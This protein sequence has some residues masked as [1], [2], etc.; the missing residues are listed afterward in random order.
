M[1]ILDSFFC[2]FELF[3]RTIFVI[4]WLISVYL[5][6]FFDSFYS[7]S[8]NFCSFSTRFNSIL[9]NFLQFPTLNKSFTAGRRNL[10]WKQRRSD[11]ELLPNVPVHNHSQ[12]PERAC[13]FHVLAL[14]TFVVPRGSDHFNSARCFDVFFLC[15]TKG[16]FF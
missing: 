16:W 15:S 12:Q 5:N 8:T 7:F 1:F 10:R 3:F 2:I 11:P 4:F 13:S 6:Y 14:Q 9:T